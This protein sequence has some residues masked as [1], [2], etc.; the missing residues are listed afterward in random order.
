MIGLSEENREREGGRGNGCEA[1]AGTLPAKASPRG[2][3]DFDAD[4][5]GAS[6]TP[7]A[8]SAPGS[9]GNGRR[10]ARSL[11]IKGLCLVGGAFLLKHLTKTTTRRDHARIVAQSLSG[12]KVC[13]RRKIAQ[14]T[15]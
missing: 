13:G 10:L 9:G 11:V 4:V 15:R 2:S 7:E 6:P 5:A 14:S 8:G 12:E 1:M 3:L